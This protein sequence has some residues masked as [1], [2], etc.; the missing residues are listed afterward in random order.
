MPEYIAPGVYIEETSFRAK[1]IEGVSTSTAAFVGPCRFGPVDGEPSLLTSYSE[2]EQIY[3]GLDKLYFEGQ[4]AT[5]NYVAHAV[6]AF[7]EEGGSRLYVARIYLP[8]DDS[9]GIARWDSSDALPDDAETNPIKLR[10][11]YPGAAGEFSVTFTI[12]PGQNLL[13]IDR[14]S[15]P[16]LGKAKEGDVIWAQTKKEASGASLTSG[17][18]YRVQYQNG[19]LQLVKNNDAA[20]TNVIAMDSLE[21]AHLPTVTVKTSAMGRLGQERVWDDLVFD[22]SQ[23]NSLCSVFAAES[24]GRLPAS[25]IPLVFE[26]NEMSGEEIAHVLTRLGNIDDGSPINL[27]LDS[28]KDLARSARV[29]LSGGS[30]GR[31]PGSL[32]YRG[33]QLNSGASSGLLS[34][35]QIEDISIVAAPGSTHSFTRV[36][37]AAA[38]AESITREVISHCERM[39]DRVAVLDSIEG[40]V[41]REVLD[42][43]RTFDS[44][45]AALYFPWV[46]IMDPITNKKIVNPPSGHICGIYARTDTERGVHKAPANEVIRLATGFETGVTK[47][48]QEVLNPEGINCLRSIRGRGYRVWGARTISSDPEWKY[49]NV[50]RY[51]AYLERSI[52]AGT[53]WAVFE[54][55]GETLWNNV[56]STVESFLYNEWKQ[57][58]MMGTAPDE[59]YFVRCDRTTM[60]QNDLDN[61]RMICL[62][63]VAPLKPAEFVIFRIGQKTSDS[64][65]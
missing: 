24:A 42:F 50:R 29:H 23:S 28:A 38:H 52:D 55:N 13:G 36:K 65:S 3:G 6:R 19:V 62:I 5:H 41:T 61:G 7:F 57:G 37:D 35:E 45:W 58:R 54:N 26:A 12:N 51:F 2:F 63:G 64:V 44:S 53:R 18:F 22:P 10:A 27:H 25:Q 14:Y 33:G 60:T 17:Q 30:D 59:A 1:A 4:D 31:R 15:N 20:T 8:T 49:V 43:R 46:R 40:S 56:K 48:Q 21:R 47:R 9:D 39:R 34:L 16:K 32:Q 11:R